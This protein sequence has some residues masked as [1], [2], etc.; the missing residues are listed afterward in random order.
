MKTT[1]FLA[2]VIML[3]FLMSPLAAEERTHSPEQLEELSKGGD[4]SA[5][6][7]RRP[8][9]LPDLTKGDLIPDGKKGPP[10]PWT[11]GPSGAVGIF[12]GSKFKG[13]QIQVQATLKGSPAEGKLLR[14]DVII[15]MNGKKF[16]AGGHLGHLI[17]K[18]IV[19]AEREKNGGKISFQ[20]WRDQN[21][22]KRSGKKDI[23]SVDIDDLFDKAR[24]DNTLYEWKAEEAREKEA[25]GFG[26]FPI[27][28]IT[29][30]VELTL[31]VLPDYSDTAPYDCPKTNQI[32]EEAWKVL[33][34]KFVA[35]P[36][37]PR[38]GRGGM[39]EAIALIAS[40]KPEHRKLVH[41]WVRSKNARQWHPPTVPAGAMF[42]PGYK[43][44]KGYQSWHHGF[45]GLNCALYYDATGD[46]FVLP[47]LRKFA[48]DA[49]MGQSGGGS[50]GHT[51]AFP[52]FNGGEFHRMNPGYGALNAAGNRCFFL[53]ALAKKLGV[54]HPEVDQAIERAHRFFGSYV[55]Q[56]AIPYGDHGPAGTD[57][58]NGKNTGIA[59]A[60]KLLGNKHGAKFFAQMSTHCSF[61]RRGGHAHDYH[62]NWS[63]W[64]ATLCGREGRILAERNLRWRRTLCRMFDGSFIY[65][66]PTGDYKTL[67][68]P[69]A[70][71]V[72]HQ[73]VALKQTLITG[74]DL[75]EDLFTSKEEMKQLL[76][77]ARPQLHDPM[78]IE[79]AS[80]PWREW[81]TDEIFGMINIFQPQTRGKVAA[82]LGK[83]FQAGEKAIAPR[84]VELLSS[85]DARS[86]DGAC[87]AL[88]A[89][90][91]DTV[92]GSLSKVTQLLDD[93]KGFVRVTAVK[94]ISKS[95]DAEESQLALL[96]ATI[97]EPKGESPNSVRNQTQ[98]ALFAKATKLGRSPFQAGFDEELVRQAIED[99]L[100]LD[101]VG[102]HGF[103]TSR[104]KIW[105]K[106][107]IARIAGPLTFA[108][109]EE[110][111][112]E[113]MFANRCAPAQAMLGK[114]GYREAVQAAAH[115]LRK[116]VAIS[117]HIRPHVGYK[118]NLIDPGA[119][120]K[121]PAAFHEFIEPLGV[122]LIDDPLTQ[123]M[124]LVN[125]SKVYYD[126]DKFYQL[127]V[128]DKKP[129]VLPSIAQDVQKIFQAKLDAVD[130]TGAKMKLCRAELKDPARKNY[131]R[132]M[133]A[134]NFLSE[135]L[136]QDAVQDLL[137]YLGHD[138]WRLRQ[139]S[140]KLAVALVPAVGESGL[141][142]L[143][144]KT[145]DEKARAGLLEV[146][147]SAHSSAG[148]KLAKQAMSHE[149][150]F[151]RQ[152]A[153]KAAF[154]I[155]GDK[156]LPDVLDHLQQATTDEDLLGCEQAILS[157]RDDPAHV[158]KVSKAIVAMLP[159]SR[160]SARPTLHYILAQLGDVESMAALKKEGETDNMNVFRN[161]VFALSY[162]P[163][164]EADRVLLD[165]A[166]SGPTKAKIVG[167][168]S[169]RRMVVGPQGYGDI[170]SKQR[171]DF[172]DAML[173]LNLDKRL[174]AY[175]GQIHE[176][177]A[178][179]TLMYCLRKGV[180]T[181]AGSLI[182]SAEGMGKLSAADGK[183]AAK[184]LQ[185]VIEYI[186]VT[187]LRGGVS[188]KDYRDYPKWK[189]LQARAGKVLLKVHQPEAAPIEGFDPMELDD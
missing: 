139:H 12:V 125:D 119:V 86:R 104:A 182:A 175:L 114:F 7:S 66:T 67:R 189:G 141:T 161:L 165:F 14:G 168:Q 174:I 36:R 135:T 11:L 158:A 186:E 97:A 154:D 76:A 123:V 51:F 143:Y 72:L 1:L 60:M 136:A 41:D 99:V 42:K 82:E 65:H 64:A 105:D 170:T 188:G 45:T 160:E 120:E 113:Q 32:L 98:T 24:N 37:K 153:V 96:K 69:T 27:D 176:A 56:G 109:E 35:D 131:F 53:I 184:S 94:A 80:K 128:A 70:T 6:E 26:E 171:L 129:I 178:L 68:D 29:L 47:A 19:E 4:L 138:Y 149:E 74:K 187:Q 13:D 16:V 9:K 92:L 110:Q 85:E 93:P 173:R 17:G 21:Y 75:D 89:C 73:A 118:R 159:K 78:L 167:A 156:L 2:P 169:V 95:S 62:G 25:R 117:R 102:G 180:S 5:A 28:P 132:K 39:L 10:K 103:V 157:R 130:G 49:A 127:I 144:T 155:G 23:V 111:V 163:S 8:A 43:G 71:E 54:D 137:P 166:R 142:A 145:K 83:R 152:A 77:S 116:K 40:G 126:M 31:R 162:S 185:D 30:E 55:D 63:S 57:D 22:F 100:Q 18:G 108:A 52:S 133:A 107:T 124:K 33:E 61:T 122:V 148:L 3:G 88:L 151:V 91:T 84:L 106:D 20:V 58:S 59:F 112:V 46:D 79:R 101:P 183:I 134:M 140:Q 38:S 48:I 150:P 146:L 181:A 115:R 90:G 121:Q 177:R 87:R 179:K 15:G 164:R 81:S 172:A 34:K 44:Y 147:A 50:W